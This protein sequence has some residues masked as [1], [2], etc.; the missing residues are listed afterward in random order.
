MLTIKTME[1][2][3][4]RTHTHSHTH[5][6]ARTF[7]VCSNISLPFQAMNWVCV[8]VCVLVTQSYPTFCDLM[9]C[10]PLG[11]SVHG[12]SQARLLEWV[13]VSFFRGTSR[14]RDQTH[15]STLPADSLLSEPLGKPINWV[16][17]CVCVFVCVCVYIYIYSRCFYVHYCKPYSA[18]F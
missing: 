12:T 1:Q 13:A 4:P 14:S 15:V 6:G 17:V 10:S 8:C 2:L 16:C 9:D 7:I 3:T 11:S 5:I 18:M